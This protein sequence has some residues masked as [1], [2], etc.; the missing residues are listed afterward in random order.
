M[1]IRMAKFLKQTCV[2]WRKTGSGGSGQPIYAPPVEVACRWEDQNAQVLTPDNR[3]ITSKA[4]LMTEYLLSVGSLVWLGTLAGWRASPAYPNRPT[5]L[6][7]GYE[8]YKT[9]H[10]PGIKGEPLLYEAWA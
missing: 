8:L 10:T 7:G 4:Y 1:A 5:V 3:I 9:A 2:Y 6:Q